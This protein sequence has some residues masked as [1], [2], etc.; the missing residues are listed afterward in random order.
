MLLTQAEKTAYYNHFIAQIPL[1]PSGQY[2][3]SDFFNSSLVSEPVPSV[4]RIAKAFFHD[5]KAGKYPTV[6]LLGP[7]SACGYR[8]D[9]SS[10]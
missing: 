6:S 3:I 9:N 2:S 4:P 7:T 5:V 10:I 8:I 1:M